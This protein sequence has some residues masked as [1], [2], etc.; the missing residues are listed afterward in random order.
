MLFVDG[1]LPTGCEVVVG[2][3]VGAMGEELPRWAREGREQWVNTGAVRPPF[4]DVPGPGQESVWDYPRPPAFVPDGRL[5]EV[6]G[7]AGPL[8]STTRALRVL[9]TSQAPAF[10][11]P[12]DDLVPGGLAPAPGRSL[13]EWKGE[14]EY[15]AVAAT[16][17]V[18]S[19]RGDGSD[20]VGVAR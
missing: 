14:A 17:E 9:E 11:V 13:C 12:P 10:Y 15:L 19:E 1:P 16:G 3:S 4:A 5:V 8:A 20:R 2:R 18:G 7:P 6:Q